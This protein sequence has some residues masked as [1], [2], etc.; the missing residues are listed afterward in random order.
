MS[1]NIVISLD[2]RKPKQD[3]SFPLIMRLTHFRKTTSI[4]TGLSIQKGDWDSQKRQVKKGFNGVSSV[5]RLNNQLAKKKAL[6]MDVITA[7]DE[8]DELPTVSVA[9]LKERITKHSQSNSLFSFSEE[10]IRD[11]QEAGRFGTALSYKDTLR[12]N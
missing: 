9:Q 12:A 7:L 2:T 6:A 10:L 4:S 11:F 3:G 8:R 5:T 1:T